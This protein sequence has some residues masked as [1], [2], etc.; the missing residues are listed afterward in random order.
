MFQNV[1][2]EVADVLPCLAPALF[3]ILE[4]TLEGIQIT[5][6]PAR[7]EKLLPLVQAPVCQAFTVEVKDVE[8]LDWRSVSDQRV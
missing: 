6:Q 5:K 1:L 2:Q 3:D 4:A 7:M 8:D